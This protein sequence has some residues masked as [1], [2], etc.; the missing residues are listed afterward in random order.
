MRLTTLFSVVAG[1]GLM[2]LGIAGCGGSVTTSKSQRGWASR[3]ARWFN[4]ITVTYGT[5]IRRRFP[6]FVLGTRALIKL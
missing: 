5:Q 4:V 6:D 2:T 1:A 3:K